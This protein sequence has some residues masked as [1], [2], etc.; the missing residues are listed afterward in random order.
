MTARIAAFYFGSSPSS[1]EAS[2][3]HNEEPRA[4]ASNDYDNTN[5]D[6]SSGSSSSPRFSMRSLTSL[7]IGKKR[8]EREKDAAPSPLL[9]MKG[10]EEADR[11]HSLQK[12][13]IKELEGE[14][15]A[16][17]AD[18]FSE[19][20]TSKK[21]KQRI[22]ELEASL[23]DVKEALLSA[24]EEARAAVQAAAM[25]EAEAQASSLEAKERDEAKAAA[26]RHDMR[27]SRTWALHQSDLDAKLEAL[28]RRVDADEA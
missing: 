28:R 2:N 17:H 21:Q 10:G 5:N 14:N 15:E 1:R 16:L 23:A 20:M 19:K 4:A 8:E 22:S 11:E 12:A 13:R 7:I 24:K 18:L 9:F 6:N 25:A 3:N 27:I 26:L